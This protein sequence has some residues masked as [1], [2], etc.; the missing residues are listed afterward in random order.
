MRRR[1][2]SSASRGW[3]SAR[4]IDRV[5]NRARPRSNRLPLAGIRSRIAGRG[6][7]IVASALHRYPSSAA[8]RSQLMNP[9]SAIRNPQSL[10]PLQPLAQLFVKF[11]GVPVEANDEAE[12]ESASAPKG[13]RLNLR[14][15]DFTFSPPVINRA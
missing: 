14:T 12:S 5:E 13:A 6:L 2:R 9:Q 3:Q 7:R 11:A 15:D 8:R 4:A 10:H 1:A